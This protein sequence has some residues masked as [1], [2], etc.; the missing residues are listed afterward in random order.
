[1]VGEI[2][3]HAVAEHDTLQMTPLLVGSLVTVAVNCCVAPAWR[4]AWL[5]VTETVTPGMLTVAEADA[6]DKATELAVSVTFKPLSG[7]VLGAV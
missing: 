5:G 1:V 2:E 7:V 4:L 6:D 3:P